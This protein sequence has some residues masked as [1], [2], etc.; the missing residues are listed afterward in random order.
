MGR[1]SQGNSRYDNR[2]D[3]HT[4]LSCFGQI[5]QALEDL[6]QNSYDIVLLDIILSDNKTLDSIAQIKQLDPKIPIVV[7]TN[8]N[9][10]RLALEAVRQ[11]AQDYLL[12][13]QLDGEL[14]IRTINH[15]IERQRIKDELQ[16]QI[17]RE[18]LLRRII[19]RIFYS[20][21]LRTILDITVEEVRQFF[22]SARVSIYCYKNSE[23]SRIVAESIDLNKKQETATIIAQINA[24][25]PNP[26]FADDDSFTLTNTNEIEEL[27]QP[28]FKA[29]L[30]VPIWRSLP[31]S[32]PVLWGQLIIQDTEKLR[33]WQFWEIEF[34]KQLAAHLAIAIQQSELYQIVEKQALQDGLTGIA[35]RRQ[36]DQVLQKLWRNLSTTKEL[37]TI[38]MI[39]VDFFSEYNNSYGHLAGDD[40]LKKIAQAIQQASQRET[41]LACRYGGEEFALILA[42]TDTEGALTVARHI[43]QN[44]KQLQLVHTSSDVSDYVTIS[45]GIATCIPTS[46]SVPENLIELADQALRQ[47]KHEGRDRIVI[48]QLPSQ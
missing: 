25:I 33:H 40:C 35:N 41:D 8:L 14:L 21:E 7:L 32:V 47:A 18:R 11:G 20:F 23:P 36:F 15:A 28:V 4:I 17:A 10:K 30:A 46:F 13:S 43:Q 29:I 22:N 31:N 48:S 5:N 16:Q 26:A 39:D 45:L 24:F 37:L 9:D 27:K 12:K 1:R 44:I 19:Q 6:K 3:G 42:K 2:S 38:I 34:L